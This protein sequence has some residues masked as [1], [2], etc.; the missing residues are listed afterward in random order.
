MSAW[1][2]LGIEPTDDTVAIRRA[3]AR[4]LKVTRPDSD[5]EGFQRLLGAR[6]AALREASAMQTQRVATDPS[7]AT[8]AAD[9]LADDIQTTNDKRET[10]ADGAEPAYRIVMMEDIL[11]E[12]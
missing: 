10:F 2:I 3:Y 8:N 4:K 6:E 1:A 5:P 9:V 12:D 11:A 7:E